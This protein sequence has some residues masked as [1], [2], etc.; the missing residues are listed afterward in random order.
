MIKTSS[1]LTHSFDS[2]RLTLKPTGEI[3]HHSA[4][5]L[6]EEADALIYR[7]RPALLTID[8]SSIDFMD[9]SGLGLIMGRYAL[10][11]R[12]GGAMAVLDP[13]PAV[14]RIIR[15]AG[16]DKMVPIKIGKKKG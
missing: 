14:I 7:T 11:K 16:M 9:S 8:L 6:R 5:S 12:Y 13:S 3:D 15:L 1:K 2:G 4:I 10:V